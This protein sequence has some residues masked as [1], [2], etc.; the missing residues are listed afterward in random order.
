MSIYDDVDDDDDIVDDDED[1]DDESCTQHTTPFHA[2][3]DIKTLTPQII[4]SFEC[5][6]PYKKLTNTYI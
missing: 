6:I 5:I 3:S 2:K 4:I 1:A